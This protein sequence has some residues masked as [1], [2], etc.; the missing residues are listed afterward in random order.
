MNWLFH[1][2]KE[3]PP[4]LELWCKNYAHGKKN[5]IAQANEAPLKFIEESQLYLEYFYSWYYITDA[6]FAQQ[7]RDTRHN[8]YFPQRMGKD[9]IEF[10][11]QNLETLP[12]KDYIPLGLICT[13]ISLSLRSYEVPTYIALRGM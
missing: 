12:M 8:V 13:D 2:W 6:A 4:K 9:K 5:Y 3:D 7:S 10:V 11:V 1:L